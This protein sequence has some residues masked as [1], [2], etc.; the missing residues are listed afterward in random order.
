MRICWWRKNSVSRSLTCL[1]AVLFA[2]SLSAQPARREL[3]VTNTNDAGSGSLRQALLD[4]QTRCATEPCTIVFQ[5]AAPLPPNGWYTI[6]PL[7]QLPEV[8]GRVII[9]GQLR[10]G[11]PEVELLGINA[12]DSNG[13]VLGQG[14]E[15]HVLG[16]AING[17][18]RSGIEV[19]RGP[20][21]Q[22]CISD[23]PDAPISTL[24]ARNLLTNNHR[25][26]MVVDSAL[27]TIVDNTIADNVRS[28]IYATGGLYVDIE[29]NRISRNG[30]SG[31]F[32]DVGLRPPFTA[33]G[34]EVLENSVVDNGEWG[35]ARTNRGEYAI[36]RNAIALN[37][38]L[39]I[40][41]NLDFET[42]NAV[43]D[44]YSRGFVT[45]KPVLFSARYDPARGKTV[46]R[47]HVQTR[48]LIGSATDID[49]YAS[50]SLSDVGQAQA[51]QWVGV[52]R[53]PGGDVDTDVTIELDG[54]LRGLFITA[55][56]TRTHITGFAKPPDVAS[57][58]HLFSIMVDTSELSNVVVAQ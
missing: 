23:A 28:G 29:R 16:L 38:Y 49:V 7:S 14:C 27:V 44:D 47:G 2:V 57:D 9:D 13:L 52:Q 30:G 11:R 19:L 35:I 55:T 53:L 33:G 10:A 48:N 22:T 5:I 8:R 42:P 21:D 31:M 56:A 6:R 32:L 37:R 26:V 12:G 36:Q 40:D 4:A 17:F 18:V 51:E 39:G 54:D 46:V 34:A 43:D 3:V 24:I 58:S 1:V 50:R 20:F 15:L 45:N 25:G 41:V